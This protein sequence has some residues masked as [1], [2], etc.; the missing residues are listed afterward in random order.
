MK[1]LTVAPLSTPQTVTASVLKAISNADNLYL[2]TKLHPSAK[3]VL[4]LDVPFVDM[5]DIYE[6]AAD[7][8]ELNRRIANRLTEGGSCVY[9]VMG[10]G[11]FSQMEDIE[12]CCRERGFKLIVL[13]AV[14]YAKAAFPKQQSGVVQTA[15][16]LNERFD[17]ESELYIQEL[18]NRLLAGEVK[19]K[20]SHFYPY[21]HEVVLARLDDEGEYRHEKLQL[22]NLDRAKNLNAATVLFVPPVTFADKT[23]FGYYDLVSVMARLRQR[24]GCP[25][26]RE[27]T[28]DSLKRALLEECYELLEAIEQKNNEHILEELGD[29]LMQVV[30]HAQIAAEQFRFN[31]RDV[32]DGVVKKLIFR[33]PH[34][35]GSANAHT[36]DEVL[37]LWDAKKSQE[38]NYTTQ[39]ELL[40]SVPKNFPA[41][42]RCQKVQKKAAKCGF[43]W[44]DAMAV[45]SKLPEEAM[46]LKKAMEKG[47]GIADELGDVFFTA[48]NIA[49]HLGMDSEEICNR[50][51]DK[52]VKRFEVMERLANLDGYKLEDLSLQIQDSYW[53]LAKKHEKQAI[54]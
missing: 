9:A 31:E 13:A 46:E 28:H 48:V 24:D 41:L 7:F 15:N 33:H 20:L 26:D 4:E 35:F 11:C 34:I 2:Q 18:D 42:I 45:F 23:E 19:L 12:R 38:K 17:T 53:E 54:N 21:S 36:S 10:D 37:E 44:S 50:A 1:T 47:E 5:D 43:D 3:T 49:R 22:C 40:N 32:S 29:V 39:T 6:S 30:F 52:F 8:S 51:T 14:S 16:S 25:W 27:Q